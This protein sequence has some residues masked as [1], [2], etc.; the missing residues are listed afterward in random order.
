MGFG[1]NGDVIRIIRLFKPLNKN[2]IVLSLNRV[3]LCVSMAALAF[4]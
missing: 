4:W 3:L 2:V 1:Q